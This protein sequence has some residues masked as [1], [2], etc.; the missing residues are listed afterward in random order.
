MNSNNNFG[1]VKIAEVNS[2]CGAGCGYLGAT[3]IEMLKGHSDRMYSFARDSNEY[4]RELF[5]EFGP[6]FWYYGSQ[7]AYKDA[8][9]DR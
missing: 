9:I 8:A 1:G 3:G 7:L 6:N 4:D 2:T 5:Y